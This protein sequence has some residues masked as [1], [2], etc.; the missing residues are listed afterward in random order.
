M[1]SHI[2]LLYRPREFQS[3]AIAA[4]FL[5]SILSLLGC[6]IANRAAPIDGNYRFVERV[7]DG[8]TLVLASG[9][10]VRLI[11]VDTPETKH[12][13]KT[14]QHFGKEAAAFTRRVVEGR[15]VRLE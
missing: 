13:R 4:L 12:P 9:E 5:C 3:S 6:I 14:V 8:D 2:R 7:I 10:R 11:G 15:R 1:P